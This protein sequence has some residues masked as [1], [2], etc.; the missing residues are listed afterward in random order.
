MMKPTGGEVEIFVG[1]EIDKKFNMKQH[2]SI[3]NL[4]L[5]MKEEQKPIAAVLF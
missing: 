5:F 4:L 1:Q 2:D 3:V